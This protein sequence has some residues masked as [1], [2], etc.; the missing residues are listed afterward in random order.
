MGSQM[1]PK[2]KKYCFSTLVILFLLF[3]CDFNRQNEKPVIS[4][5]DDNYILLL[6]KKMQSV[7]KK[8]YPNFV[9]WETSDYTNKIV[10]RLKKDKDF[11]RAPFALIADVNKDGI[12]DV[13]LDGHDNKSSLLICVLSQ[14]NNYKTVLISDDE[15]IN[16]KTIENVNDGIKENG[17]NYFLWLP[18]ENIIKNQTPVPV[19]TVAFPQQTDSQGELLRDGDI[20]DYYFENGVFRAEE[21]PL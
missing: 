12:L 6:P 9:L 8:N 11:K 1:F 18:S 5:K 16:P 19:F 3:S 15:L 2:N 4:F 20:V 14:G 7:I 10:N 13:I 17:N 21:S